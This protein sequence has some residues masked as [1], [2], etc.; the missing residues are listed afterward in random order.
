MKTGF[1]ALILLAFAFSTLSRSLSING[2]QNVVK[3]EVTHS[4]ETEHHHSDKH[5]HESDHDDHHGSSAHENEHE[6]NQQPHTHEILVSVGHLIVLLS[7]DTFL[8]FEFVP[9]QF[10]QALKQGHLLDR[11]LDSIFRPPIHV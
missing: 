8:A 3:I 9:N 1:I 6:K 5:T 10:P 11:P 4:H 2:L 7:K